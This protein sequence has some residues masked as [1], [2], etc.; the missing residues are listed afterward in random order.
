M[1]FWLKDGEGLS[2]VSWAVDDKT[3]YVNG[4]NLVGTSYPALLRVDL[5][6]NVTVLRQKHYEWHVMPKVS[7]DGRKIAFASMP[8]HGNVWMVEDF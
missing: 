8:F 1:K 2:Y 7:P 3:L 4:G 6:G 5:N